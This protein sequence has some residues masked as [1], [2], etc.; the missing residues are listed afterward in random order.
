MPP[1][2]PPSRPSGRSAWPVLF[3]FVGF[4]ILLVLLGRY[5]IAPGI[6]TLQDPAVDAREKA[7]LKAYAALLLILVLAL[8]FIGLLLVFRIRRLFFPQQFLRYKTEYPDAWTES[9]RRVQVTDRSIDDE[10]EDEDEP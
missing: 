1:I 2:F 5:W 8:S 4:A 9:G 7:T 6:E 3:F 10:D